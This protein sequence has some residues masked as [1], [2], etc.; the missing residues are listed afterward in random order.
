MKNCFC[1]IAF[2]LIAIVANAQNSGHGK[3]MTVYKIDGQEQHITSNNISFVRDGQFERYAWQPSAGIQSEYGALGE[4]FDI[5]NVK[6]IFRY[7]ESENQF[8]ISIP[9]NAPID[10]NEIVVKAYGEEISASEGNVYLTGADAVSV[11]NK[12]GLIIYDSYASVDTVNSVRTIQLNAMETAF[13]LLLPIFPFVFEPMSDELL[14]RM[15]S[16]LAELSET[17]AL[18]TAID[19][20]IIKNGFLD[21][22]DIDVEYKVAVESIINRL[23]LRETYLNQEYQSNSRRRVPKNPSILDGDKAWGLKLIL[24]SSEWKSTENFKG[25]KCN[26]T[27]YNSNRFAY[28]AWARGF[29]DKDGFA[30]FYDDDPAVLMQNM[31]KPQRASTFMDTFTSWSGLKDYFTDT[32]KLAFEEDFGWE[33]MTWDNTKMTFDMS[34]I[35]DHDVV[36]V[37]EPSDN[38]FMLYY[39][40]LK[41]LLSPIVKHI[42]K[43]LNPN[44]AEGG[45]DYLIP[46]ITDLLADVDYQL[47]FNQIWNSST[48]FSEKSKDILVLTWPKFQVYIEKYATEKF[49]LWT[50][51]QMM[52]IWG[53]IPTANFRKAMEDISKNWNK[54]LKTTEILG[55]MFLGLLG[56]K[57]TSFYYDM[58]LDF[59]DSTDFTMP[60]DGLV[61]YYPFNESTNDES[62]YGNHGMIEGDVTY[63]TGVNRND[64]KA[65]MFNGGRIVVGNPESLRFTDGCTFA[66]FVKPTEWRGMDGWG[67]TVANDNHCIFGKD[68]DQNGLS[69]LFSGDS[70]HFNVGAGS[71]L[72]KSL[73]IGTEN[74]V[75]GDYLNKWIHIALVYSSNSSK[76]Y[77]DGQLVN[78]KAAIP[79]FSGINDKNLTIGRFYVSHASPYW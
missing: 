39:N 52:E 56:L 2:A 55:D 63:T 53:F 44:S 32:Y 73:E 48:Q 72:Y 19:Q 79:D 17:Q 61:L 6:S 1:T 33:D 43:S 3:F 35:S 36:I 60:T 7:T 12:D 78:E 62:G 71:W 45:S 42:S 54:Y 47:K 65:V 70:E 30:H 4:V 75:E 41:T 20:S 51:Q 21:I 15:K 40:V 10:E 50:E 16:L 9:E 14:T 66:M 24:N 69:F 29:K 37:A 34:F 8:V 59:D 11:V 18:A 57:E 31:L 67:Y 13:T 26:L 76:I 5:R 68:N 27:A 49:N 58:S 46:F 38:D 28:T 77:I 64:S 23:G 22:G 25:W 74:K